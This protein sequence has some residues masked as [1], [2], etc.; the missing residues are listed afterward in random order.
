MGVLDYV[1]KVNDRFKKKIVEVK[2]EEKPKQPK[3]RR[4]TITKENITKE[5]LKDYAAKNHCFTRD[6]EEDIVY[7]PMGNIMRHKS[8]H[9]DGQKYCAKAACGKCTNRCTTARFKEVVFRE[10]QVILGDKK[11]K[12]IVI[13]K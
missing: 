2:V 4:L 10:G 5:Y 8:R 1:R 12:M 11:G 6:L 7:C 13:V 3:Y 9:R